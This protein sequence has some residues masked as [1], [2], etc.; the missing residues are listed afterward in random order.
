MHACFTSTLSPM[1]IVTFCDVK[2]QMR[3]KNVK[4]RTRGR[5][6]PKKASHTF[7]PFLALLYMFSHLRYEKI[8][9]LC[10]HIYT[11][12]INYNVD[13]GST[14]ELLLLTP[15]NIHIMQKI[16]GGDCDLEWLQ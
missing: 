2:G 1:K 4:I 3:R 11:T 13:V 8:W 6:S 15:I 7:S 14:L 16:G 12:V 10:R 9:R 5:N